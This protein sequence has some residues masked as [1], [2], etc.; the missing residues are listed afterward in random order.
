MRI[1]FFLLALFPAALHAQQVLVRSGEHDSFTRLVFDLPQGVNWSISDSE[2]L[3]TFLVE[4]DDNT[5][6][7]NA[8]EVFD[9]I[10]RDRVLSLL[11]SPQEAILEVSMNCLCEYN[12]FLLGERMLVI[13]IKDGPPLPIL[14]G[15]SDSA[16][17]VSVLSNDP[18]AQGI[19]EL[20]LG[21]SPGIGPVVSEGFMLPAGLPP[22]DSVAGE[23]VELAQENGPASKDQPSFSVGGELAKD[24][25]RAATNGLLDVNA[26]NAETAG[27]PENR[28][29]RFGDFS[30]N[31]RIN[32]ERGDGHMSIG[33]NSCYLDDDLKIALWGAEGSV[34]RVFH[35]RAK[36]FG[37]FDA[38]DEG[39]L[40]QHVKSLLYFGFGAEARAALSMLG[41]NQSEILS[42]MSHII[43]DHVDPN[44]VFAGQMACN[45]HSL[46]WALISGHVSSADAPPDGDA[47]LRTFEELPYHLRDALGNTLVERL[48]A[49]GLPNV[50]RDVLRRLERAR[51]GQSSDLILAKARVELQIGDFEQAQETLDSIDGLNSE[52]A[53]SAVAASVELA[54]ETDQIVGDDLGELAAAYASEYRGQP[55]GIELQVAHIRALVSQGEYQSAFSESD[56][57]ELPSELMGDIEGE[58]WGSIINKAEDLNFLMYAVNINS[59]ILHGIR[60]EDRHRLLARL[61]DLGMAE[62]VLSHLEA[63]EGK[64]LERSFRLIKARALLE[65]SR[66]E[67]AEIALVGLQ[68][69]EVMELRALARNEMGDHDFASVVFENAEE[70][71]NA[72]E[73]AFMA[74]DWSRVAASNDQN[75]SRMA[76]LMQRPPQDSNVE[77]LAYAASLSDSSFDTRAA[78]QGMLEATRIPENIDAR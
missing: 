9:R 33:S 36:I 43:D 21:S 5:L 3:G 10:G 44:G 4:L 47:I 64:M 49:A 73:A 72:Q 30:D 75:L 12:S 39:A 37:E 13:D 25:A 54:F 56:R 8:R 28:D 48:T 46:F 38:I 23:E 67:E 76:E 27:A 60:P 16:A 66:P 62:V 22:K 50:A 74:G 45:G 63:A 18:R 55:E 34:A 29:V 6:R 70:Y 77:S 69:D 59:S 11:A 65:L 17:E 61:L 68:G 24:L 51:G 53:A 2:N 32:A 14:S 40:R 1:L 78:I 7:F 19:F 71:V 26:K 57:S 20:R 41:E 31:I 58:I 15:S 35:Q 42:A 52:D